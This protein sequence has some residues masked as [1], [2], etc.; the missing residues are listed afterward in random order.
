MK[1]LFLTVG[2]PP[3]FLGGA[4]TYYYNI[5]HRFPKEEVT[6][7][8]EKSRSNNLGS[9]NRIRYIRRFYI[10]PRIY[11]QGIEYYV[12]KLPGMTRLIN[13]TAEILW[14]IELI[15]LCFVGRPDVIYVGQLFRTGKLGMRLHK[16]FRIPYI[17]FVH[18]EEIAKAEKKRQSIKYIKLLNNAFRVI[19]N[20]SFTR[21]L[22]RNKGI[23]NDKI[24]IVTPMVDTEIYH[25]VYDVSSLKKKYGITNEKVLLSVGRL[26]RRKGHA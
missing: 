2:M 20:S 1:F 15:L 10:R 18:G 13:V 8:T 25:P 9:D 23:D 3:P 14:S 5:F 6:I 12:K 19:C 21:D 16:L 11:S 24:E 22:V 4:G 7:F 26:T 17:I